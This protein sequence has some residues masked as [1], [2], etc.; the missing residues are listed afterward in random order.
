MPD[1]YGDTDHN[2]PIPGLTDPEL[3]AIALTVPCRYCSAKEGEPCINHT[4]KNKPP[5]RIPHPQRI[6]D[7]E[8]IP[9]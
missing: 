1:R 7:A 5:T 6:T 8:E 3:H 2:E 4:V 9:F